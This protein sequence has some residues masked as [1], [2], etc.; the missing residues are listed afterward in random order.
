MHGTS[1]PSNVRLHSDEAAQVSRTQTVSP[2]PHVACPTR[3]AR[4]R[5]HPI[6]VLVLPAADDFPFAVGTA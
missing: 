1:L 6:C 5:M 4:F 3:A 2:G